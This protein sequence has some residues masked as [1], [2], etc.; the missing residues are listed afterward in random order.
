V[1][2]WRRVRVW[3][4]GATVVALFVVAPVVISRAASA[5]AE[6]DVAATI[7]AAQVKAEGAG[8]DV[9]AGFVKGKP[10][11]RGGVVISRVLEDPY[12]LIA[13]RLYDKRGSFGGTARMRTTDGGATWTG[14][15]EVRGLGT[16]DSGTGVLTFRT[17]R[18]SL[19]G[20]GKVR[21]RVTGTLKY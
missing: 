15:A 8:E 1:R 19:T 18:G 20:D 14:N 17:T 10:L 3:A 9:L 6:H 16:Y 5:G 13:F 7:Y 21:L 4:L 12:I 2:S 11:G